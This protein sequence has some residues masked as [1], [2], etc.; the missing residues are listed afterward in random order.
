MLC[1]RADHG[2]RSEGDQLLWV[3]GSICTMT[4]RLKDSQSRHHD[5]WFE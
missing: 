2:E 4:R 1:Y 3:R 5:Y